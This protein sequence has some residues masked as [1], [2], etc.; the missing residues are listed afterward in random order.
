[1]TIIAKNNPKRYDIFM[2]LSVIIPVYNEERSLE[3]L[4]E[5]VAASDA[6]IEKEII[7]V[8]DGS[9]DQT[10][11]I[12]ERLRDRFSLH[13]IHKNLNEGKG[14]AI[15]SAI[16]HING[17]VAIIQDAD[18]ELDPREYSKLLEPFITYNA[19]VVFG[20]RFQMAGT[21]RVFPTGRYLANRFLTLFSNLAS[22]LYLTDMET[23]YKLFR[24]EV[25]Q[26]FHLKADRFDIEPE[27]VAQTAKGKWNIWELPIHYNPRS[28]SQGKKIGFTDGLAALWAIIR[29]NWFDK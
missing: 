10:P 9:N 16:P 4:L 5:A 15:R 1:M 12:L 20:S 27:L 18:L 19:D 11:Q 17:D 23:C 14:A 28:R 25:I 13:I 3:A 21:R 8:N 6:A 2:R 26:S 22:G 29:F 7:V 24:R